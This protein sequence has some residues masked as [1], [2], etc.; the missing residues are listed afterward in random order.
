VSSKEP[1]PPTIAEQISWAEQRH[2]HAIHMYGAKDPT[3]LMWAGVIK[4][5][6]SVAQIIAEAA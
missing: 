5:L 1:V 2:R 4:S 6:R 3:A